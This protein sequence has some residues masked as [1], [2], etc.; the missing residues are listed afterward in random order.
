MILRVTPVVGLAT[1]LENKLRVYLCNFFQ[2]NVCLSENYVDGR[3]ELN[4]YVYIYAEIFLCVI[5]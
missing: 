3:I 2:I 1:K 5:I 4:Y